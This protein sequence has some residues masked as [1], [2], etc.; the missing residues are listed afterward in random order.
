MLTNPAFEFAS[1]YV[2]ADTYRPV[3]IRLARPGMRAAGEIEID[4]MAADSVE[5]PAN[6]RPVD[7]RGIR[8]DSR[9]GLAGNR[10]LAA[11]GPLGRSR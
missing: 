3:H 9:A 11:V 8:G 2:A 4:W 10:P 1:L 7:G 6:A 5:P